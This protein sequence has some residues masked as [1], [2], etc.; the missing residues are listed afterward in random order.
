MPQVFKPAVFGKLA[1]MVIIMLKYVSPKANTQTE[2][3]VGLSQGL[4]CSI[5]EIPVSSYKVESLTK[6]VYVQVEVP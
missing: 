1:K 4:P 2:C 3:L 6:I 5:G